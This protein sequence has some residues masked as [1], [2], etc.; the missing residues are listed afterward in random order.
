MRGSGTAAKCARKLGAHGRLGLVHGGPL[1][2]SHGLNGRPVSPSLFRLTRP[3]KMRLPWHEWVVAYLSAAGDAV[4]RQV[5]AAHK[6]AGRESDNPPYRLAR[7]EHGGRW[8]EVRAAGPDS[9]WWI[10]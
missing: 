2:V 9:V 5:D 8:L 10:Y 4:Y 6:A 1:S 7:A 3:G